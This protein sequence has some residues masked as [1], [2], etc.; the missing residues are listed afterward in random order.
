M[1]CNRS[2]A[3]FIISSPLMTDNEMTEKDEKIITDSRL[4]AAIEFTY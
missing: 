1:A 4:K 2:T 3:D